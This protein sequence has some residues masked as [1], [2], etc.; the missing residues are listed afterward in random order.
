MQFVVD[1]QKIRG[2]MAE[3][4]YGIDTFAKELHINRNTLASYLKNPA[5]IPYATIS[6]MATALCDTDEEAIR[7][8]FSPQLT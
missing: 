6:S 7:I 2:K 8:F 3:K 4:G 1:V 5:K